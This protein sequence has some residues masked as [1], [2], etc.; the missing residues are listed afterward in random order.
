MILNLSDSGNMMADECV[1]II[2]GER[3]GDRDRQ[4]ASQKER[5][6]KRVRERETERECVRK[7]ERERVCEKEGERE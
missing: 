5:G 1:C 7:R 3:G 2:W 6:G 4:T